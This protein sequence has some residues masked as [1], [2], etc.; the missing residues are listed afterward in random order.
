MSYPQASKS[1]L[2]YSVSK[3]VV[4]RLNVKVENCLNIIQ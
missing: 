1:N 4:V 2:R 3:M